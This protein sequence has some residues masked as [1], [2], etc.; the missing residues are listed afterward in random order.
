MSSTVHQPAIDVH[1]VLQRLGIRPVNSGACSCDWIE[2]PGGGELISYSPIDGSEL[3]RVQMADERDYDAVVTEAAIAFESWR[4]FPAPSSIP[5]S[6]I[7]T[8]S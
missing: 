1:A 2:H 3:A 4:L 5:R 7:R 8:N 6:T